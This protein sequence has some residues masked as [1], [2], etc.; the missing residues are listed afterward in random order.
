MAD[1]PPA[2][3]PGGADE[4]REDR[5]EPRDSGDS[6]PA[7]QE[8]EEA[9][10]G[11]KEPADGEKDQA[12]EVDGQERGGD[13][14]AAGEETAPDEESQS[15]GYVDLPEAPAN[16][17]ADDGAAPDDAADDT[18]ADQE[19][20][21]ATEDAD[22]GAADT[23]KGADQ[24][25]AGTPTDAEPEQDHEPEEDEDGAAEPG[26]PDTEPE[27]DG[28]EEPGEDANEHVEESDGEAD[29]DGGQSDEEVEEDEEGE[30]SDEEVEEDEEGEQS[31]EEAEE[32]EEGE[33]SDEEAEEDE[34]GDSDEEPDE[35]GEDDEA[36]S[37]STVEM[38]DDTTPIQRKTGPAS[39][40]EQPLADHIEEMV[41]RLAIVVVVAGVVSLLAFPFGEDFILFLWYSVLP[42]DISQPHVYHPLELVI[43]QLKAASLLGLVL[44]LPVFV[45]ET[46][47]FMRPGLYPHERRYYLA[48][49]PTSLILAFVGLL[50]G[51]FI[52]LPAVMNYFLYYS[53]TVVDIAFALGQTFSLMLILLGYLAIVF[54]IPL[55]VML[56]IMMGL[57]TRVW[58]EERR[59]IF[60]G[61]FLG[62]SFLFSPDPT[63]MA[64][65]VI[66]ATMVALFE[67]T[68]LLLRWTGRG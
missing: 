43:T 6:E 59:L 33:Q 19:E 53:D 55:F 56:A 61:A 50:F 28:D 30:Q 10:E 38:H 29:E 35:E 67:G 54:Q 20:E 26:A 60:W 48:A 39:D 8:R 27:E 57:T 51:Y 36:S 42:A 22:K 7:D 12:S 16:S 11:Q 23:P 32:D 44:A 13:E 14:E 64:P 49:V 34:E 17:D 66:A 24:E 15:G 68:L 63:G 58:L 62:I 5:E 31:D 4:E 18:P 21:E 3:G 2:G 47:A 9:S 25:A 40:K 46:Y 1:D 52:V 65:I 37:Q 41:K 45:Y